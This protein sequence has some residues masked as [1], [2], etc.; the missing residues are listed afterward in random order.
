MWKK[1]SIGA[2]Y[3][4]FQINQLITHRKVQLFIAVSLDGYIAGPGGDMSFLDIVAAEGEDYGYAGFIKETDTVIIGRKTYDW[5][6]TQV[7]EFPHA[8]KKT[9]I[10]TRTS[11]PR[12]GT[13]EFYTENLAD[14]IT[15]LKSANGKNIFV[16]GGAEI[17]NQLLAA[18]L[19]DEIYISIIPVLLGG[20]TRLFHDGIPQTK[21]EFIDSRQFNS[22][23]VQVHYKV[24]DIIR[25]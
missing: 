18:G 12:A 6:M 2:L 8:D 17:V 21:L 9:Y 10:I 11:R 23:L 15:H 22:G 16:D 25:E 4:A 7:G 13:I 24:K 19:I 20:G 3:R 14:L 5:V 1:V